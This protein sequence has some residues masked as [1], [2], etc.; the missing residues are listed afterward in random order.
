[1]VGIKCIFISVSDPKLCVFWK[2]YIALINEFWV[3]SRVQFDDWFLY[4][5]NSDRFLRGFRNKFGCGQMWLQRFNV[6][7]N[8]LVINCRCC[9]MYR[10]IDLGTG[11]NRLSVNERCHFYRRFLA[12]NNSIIQIDITKRWGLSFAWCSANSETVELHLVPHCFFTSYCSLKLL[13]FFTAL[14]SL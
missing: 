3:Q 12:I 11:W 10:M 9:M 4:Y 5:W 7:S 8:R 6:E 2:R 1:M 14:A 13:P